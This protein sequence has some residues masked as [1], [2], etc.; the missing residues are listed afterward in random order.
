MNNLS[1]E[2]LKEWLFL[3]GFRGESAKEE[4]K[5]V[6]SSESP[7]I[8]QSSSLPESEI[9]QKEDLDLIETQVLMEEYCEPEN[10]RANI[11]S[12]VYSHRIKVLITCLILIILVYL[13]L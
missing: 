7:L 5:N 9:I 13:A 6:N 11:I 10:P 4:N 3:N 2:Q 8:N 1:E 12:I